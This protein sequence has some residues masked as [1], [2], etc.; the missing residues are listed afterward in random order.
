MEASTSLSGK[1][2][3]A[4]VMAEGGAGRPMGAVAGRGVL[5]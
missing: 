3:D 4:T 5:Q 1:L 2:N